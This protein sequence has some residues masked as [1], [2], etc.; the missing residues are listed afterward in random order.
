M[1]KLVEGRSDLVWKLVKEI[2]LTC[3]VNDDSWYT[4]SS[5]YKDSESGAVLVYNNKA[6]G[7]SNK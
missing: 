6:T 2:C 4:L 5:E 3:S 7:K 1:A